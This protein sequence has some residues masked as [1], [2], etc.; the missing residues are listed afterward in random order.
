MKK[1]ALLT[2]VLLGLNVASAQCVNNG[3][4]G[5]FGGG[6]GS[7]SPGQLRV[8]DEIMGFATIDNVSKINSLALFMKNEVS[9]TDYDRTWLPI[10]NSADDIILELNS[11][12]TILSTRVRDSFVMLLIKLKDLQPQIQQLRSVERT[13]T[14]A[15]DV[16]LL[17]KSFERAMM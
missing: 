17:I 1:L 2:I 13:R 16:L 5:S 7:Y 15:N 4:S 6:S 9:G 11:G 14:I 3:G 12:A 8:G 10:R